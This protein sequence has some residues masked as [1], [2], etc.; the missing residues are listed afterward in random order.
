MKFTA[1]LVSA[2]AAS[3]FPSFDALHANCALSWNFAGTCDNAYNTLQNT[4]T[5][6]KDPA[7]GNYAIVQ[8][9][10]PSSIWV[11]RTTPV[12]KYVDD[13]E[14]TVGSN[15]SG[16]CTMSAKSRSQ[17]LSYYDYSTNYC[18]MFNVIRTS[19]LK[20]TNLQ[21]SQCKFPADSPSVCDKY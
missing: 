4:L 12:K 6:F 15:V 17:S 20:Y 7:G 21:A 3:S 1:A 18:N 19:G 11:T 16:S 9:N 13:I 14:F 8:K 2:T 5:N 10:S